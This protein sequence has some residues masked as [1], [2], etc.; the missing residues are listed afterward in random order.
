LLR[1]TF[2]ISDL[3]YEGI[4]N[5]PL[6]SQIGKEKGKESENFGSTRCDRGSNQHT[7]R[8]CSLR[9]SRGA[10]RRCD[11][12]CPDI[13]RNL[14][15]SDSW[16]SS[17]QPCLDHKVTQAPEGSKCHA[18][19]TNPDRGKYGTKKSFSAGEEG[20]EGTFQSQQESKAEER[21]QDPAFEQEEGIVSLQRRSWC[22]SCVDLLVIQLTPRGGDSHG[23]CSCTRPRRRGRLGSYHHH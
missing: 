19:N 23:T 10:K 16:G 15:D 4:I 6:V 12:I 13:D 2:H 7:L 9:N 5:C 11:W 1:K 22:A 8:I 21:S 14:S 18:V 3:G 20:S 17:Q